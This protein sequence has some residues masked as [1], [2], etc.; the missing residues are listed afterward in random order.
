[1]SALDKARDDIAELTEQIRSATEDADGNAIELDEAGEEAVRALTEQLT[2]KTAGAERLAEIQRSVNAANEALSVPTGTKTIER[3]RATSEVART[4]SYGEFISKQ[5]KGELSSEEAG[6][7]ERAMSFRALA[8]ATTSNVPGILPDAWLRDIVDFIGVSRP[9]ISAFD[10]KPLP[11]SGM[12]INYPRVT[13]KP[14]VAAQATEKTEVASSATTISNNTASLATYGGGEDISIQTIE[15]TDPGYLAIVMELYAEEMAVQTDQAAIADALAAITNEVTISAAA[16]AAGFMADIAG[17]AKAVLAARLG[18]P[19]SFVVGL[20]VWEF[21]AG[22]VDSEGRP[23]FP[24]TAPM[25]P[26]GST[27]ITSDATNVRGL[28]LVVD[29]NMAADTGVFGQSRAF[30]SFLGPV[31]SMASDVPSLLGRDYAV[32]QYAAFACRRPDALVEFTLG[33]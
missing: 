16:G 20:D 9:F 1:M 12:T 21:L 28:N 29:P 33:A 5:A 26:V 6:E 25:N 17:A 4:L 10:Q 32:F 22:M 15:R 11:D 30:S 19:D 2:A 3:T 14:A 24:H 7:V 31:R 23:I 18:A 13:A 8:D 27:T